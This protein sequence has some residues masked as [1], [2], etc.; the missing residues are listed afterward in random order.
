VQQLMNDF[1][2]YLSLVIAPSHCVS[3]AIPDLALILQCRIRA[4]SG[5]ALQTLA[6]RSSNK[7]PLAIK[8]I[9][10]SWHLRTV[11]CTGSL[12]L[13]ALLLEYEYEY[14]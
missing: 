7:A 14:E 3:N 10:Q 1:D 6:G 12:F 13:G 2:C 5:I 9:H 8:V 11:L 4:R